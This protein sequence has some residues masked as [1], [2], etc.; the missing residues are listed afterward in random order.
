MCTRACG[1]CNAPSP[2]CSPPLAQAVQ[3]HNTHSAVGTSERPAAMA[4]SSLAP[5]LETQDSPV[6][7]SGQGQ[8]HSHR[9]RQ[10]D[11]WP[12]SGC[13]KR[14]RGTDD[15]E[16]ERARGRRRGASSLARPSAT[17][18]SRSHATRCDRRTRCTRESSLA[19]GRARTGAEAWAEALPE[20]PSPA[21]TNLRPQPVAM[22]ASLCAVL[23]TS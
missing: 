7:F 19:E 10:I 6:T 11:L 20:P 15:G 2:P 5:T 4:F 21:D 13:N 22:V 9:A 1:C 8:S 18:C 14:P 23:Q 16:I 12:L 17:C 3:G